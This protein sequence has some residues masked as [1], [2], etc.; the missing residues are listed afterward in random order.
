MKQFM[1]GVAAAMAMGALAATTSTVKVTKFHSAVVTIREDLGG[2]QLRENG[3]YWAE[4]NV[5]AD[6]PEDYGLY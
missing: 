1:S 5:G 4:C 3:P 2:V 6:K